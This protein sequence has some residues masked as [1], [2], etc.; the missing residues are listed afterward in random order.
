MGNADSPIAKQLIYGT[1]FITMAK[2]LGAEST[3]R[4]L[5]FYGGYYLRF[6]T[7]T[8]VYSKTRQALIR[9]DVEELRSSGTAF[10]KIDVLLAKKYRVGKSTIRWARGFSNRGPRFYQ[11]DKKAIAIRA[12]QDEELLNIIAKD[13]EIWQKYGI[14]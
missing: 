13:L 2:L 11:K 4:L 7:I 9:R 10:D 6:P 5:R 1:S 14:I 12:T 3:A 8:S